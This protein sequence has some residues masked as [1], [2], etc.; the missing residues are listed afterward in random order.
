MAVSKTVAPKKKTAP[1]KEIKINTIVEYHGKQV[2]EK[3]IVAAVKKAWTK[4]GNKVGDIKT[5]E[6]YI[7]PEE[8]SVYYVI[9]GLNTGR[10]GF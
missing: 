9:N 10:V 4:A 5:I 3:V 7:K 2:E 1:K 6:I 8:E